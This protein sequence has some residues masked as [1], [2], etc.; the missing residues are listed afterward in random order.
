VLPKS[1][2]ILVLPIT[3]LSAINSIPPGP[4]T[5]RPAPVI[6]TG[7]ILGILNPVR[8][9]PLIVNLPVIRDNGSVIETTSPLENP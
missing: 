4:L 3:V 6:E 8:P 7:I 9:D 5:E 2:V 1:K